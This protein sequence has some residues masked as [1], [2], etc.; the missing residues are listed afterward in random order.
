[1]YQLAHEQSFLPLLQTHL[2][3]KGI[4]FFY[5]LEWKFLVLGNSNFHHMASLFLVTFGNSTPLGIEINANKSLRD[6]FVLV[7]WEAYCPS[8]ISHGHS[9]LAEELKKLC[10]KFL[11]VVRFSHYVIF[12]KAGLFFAKNNNVPPSGA[13]PIMTGIFAIRFKREPM[14]CHFASL[15]IKLGA[16][17]YSAILNEWTQYSSLVD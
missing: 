11:R 16:L 12:C 13:Y 14:V 6:F 1:M 5:F 3:L 2:Y 15:R 7:V 9:R 17:S 8:G 4:Y 10:K